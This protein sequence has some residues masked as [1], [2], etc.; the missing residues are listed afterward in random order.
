MALCIAIVDA[1]QLQ[2]EAMDF[3]RLQRPTG[4]DWGRFEY[5][6]ERAAEEN[7]PDESPAIEQDIHG[8]AAQYEKLEND[9]SSGDNSSSSGSDSTKTDS[10]DT[11]KEE[12][13]KDE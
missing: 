8:S 1:V 9:D 13:A 11:A 3:S 2:V 7:A 6:P 5:D 4:I 12:G 10:T